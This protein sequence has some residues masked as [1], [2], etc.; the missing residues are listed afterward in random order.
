MSHYAPTLAFFRNIIKLTLNHKFSLLE[1]NG[2]WRRRVILLLGWLFW[3][4]LSSPW[5][6]FVVWMLFLMLTSQPLSFQNKR[7]FLFFSKK[8]RELNWSL[9][10]SVMIMASFRQNVKSWFYASYVSQN[11]NNNLKENISSLHNVIILCYC[12]CFL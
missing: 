11:Y 9:L 7:P 5:L 10:L 8:P 1:Y 3:P 12:T 6:V 4:L 2:R